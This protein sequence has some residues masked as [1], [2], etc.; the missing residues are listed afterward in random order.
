LP[1]NPGSGN[2]HTGGTA[3]R[4]SYYCGTSR[5]DLLQE[6]NHGLE[7]CAPPIRCEAGASLAALDQARLSLNDAR[8][9]LAQ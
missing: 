5:V 8:A 3:L 1:G 2:A 6:A 4:Q 9:W 7:L